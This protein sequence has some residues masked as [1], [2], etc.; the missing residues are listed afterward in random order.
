MKRVNLI[1]TDFDGEGVGQHERKKFET[2][3]G[4]A[5]EMGSP[6]P[7][8]VTAANS[9]EIWRIVNERLIREEEVEHDNLEASLRQ[10]EGGLNK[11]DSSPK[12]EEDRQSTK[13]VLVR[14][15]ASLTRARQDPE[16]MRAARIRAERQI[17]TIRSVIED[18][19]G[20]G[21]IG[22]RFLRFMTRSVA[23][24][25]LKALRKGLFAWRMT[26]LSLPVSP[27]HINFFPGEHNRQSNQTAQ[28][29]A[30]ADA[31]AG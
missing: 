25:V 9:P 14:I 4:A 28:A 17:R 22:S 5:K 6:S 10:L 29:G 21:N 7:L 19:L 12:V 13:K 31:N 18:G 11:R 23:Q 26:L 27:R 15:W 2:Y 16:Q 8:P 1:V 24:L 3:W 20:M 30:P